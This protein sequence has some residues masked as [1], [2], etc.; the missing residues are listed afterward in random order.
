MARFPATE[1]GPLGPGD[2]EYPSIHAELFI[3]LVPDQPGALAAGLLKNAGRAGNRCPA[4]QLAKY[5]T[6]ASIPADK[7]PRCDRPAVGGCLARKLA[8]RCELR[9]L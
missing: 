4:W 8:A 9:E 6:A 5:D 2:F 1:P 3:L 7:S